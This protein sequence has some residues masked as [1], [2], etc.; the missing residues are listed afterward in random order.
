MILMGFYNIILA[1]L[2]YNF[3][4]ADIWITLGYYFIVTPLSGV[5][6]YDWMMLNSKEIKAKN[7][8]NAL[9]E[10]AKNE[11]KQKRQSLIDRLHALG[12]K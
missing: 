5:I 11:L 8:F 1:I 6:T 12:V 4:V 10:T 2:F 3:I 7:K 9:S